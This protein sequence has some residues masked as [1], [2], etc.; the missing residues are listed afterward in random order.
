LRLAVVVALPLVLLKLLVLSHE[1]YGGIF[2]DSA[3]TIIKQ[4]GIELLLDHDAVEEQLTGASF[5]SSELLEPSFLRKAKPPVTMIFNRNPRDIFAADDESSFITTYGSSF[6]E[7]GGSKIWPLIMRKDVSSNILAYRLGASYL[8]SSGITDEFVIMAPWD[9]HFAFI[10]SRANLSTL[11]VI[12]HDHDYLRPRP[13]G[14]EPM[15]ILKD[16][17]KNVFYITAEEYPALYSH[18]MD[19]GAVGYISFPKLRMVPMG[20]SIYAIAQSPAT[21]RLYVTASPGPNDIIEIDPDTMAVTKAL[22]LNEIGGMALAVDPS[23][24]YLY[25]QAAFDDD[26]YKIDLAAFKVVDKFDGDMAARRIILDDKRGALY[27]LGMMSGKVYALDPET[28]RKLW[29]MKV[30]PH[31]HGMALTDNY[32]WTLSMRGAFRIKLR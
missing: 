15:C 12:P 2:A 18:D 14:F 30:G 17:S 9:S 3:A 19:S 26:L 27:L 20:G 6:F 1:K 13:T 21:R 23:G 32:L 29:S 31:P 25:Y 10:V 7:P 16:V 4:P 8:Q 5:M 24:K 11:R 22:D 28:G